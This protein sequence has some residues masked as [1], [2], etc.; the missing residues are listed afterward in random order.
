[1]RSTPASRAAATT[2]STMRRPRIGCRCFGVALFMRVPSP[3]AITT[4]ARSSAMSAKSGWGARIRTWDHGTKTRCLTTW[5]R[6]RASTT[7]AALEEKQ[8]E[9]DE[10]EDDDDHDE[11]GE[12][13]VARGDDD[14]RAELRRGEQPRELVEEAR[15][16]PLG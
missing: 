14:R 13:D 5:L 15:A 11:S 1:M 8:A 4:A 2:Q 12:N 16:R 7:L 6:P 3:P 9:R 10:G